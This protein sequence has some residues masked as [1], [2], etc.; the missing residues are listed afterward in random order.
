MVISVIA[1]IALV[2]P[3]SLETFLEKGAIDEIVNL[4]NSDTTPKIQDEV[5]FYFLFCQI[6]LVLSVKAMQL[7]Y[8]V[9][10][11]NLLRLAYAT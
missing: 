8:H 1:D 7:C 2:K 6:F 10:Y 3:N 11:A 4:K 5:N 9:S